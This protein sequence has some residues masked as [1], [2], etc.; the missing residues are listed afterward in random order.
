MHDQSSHTRLGSISEDVDSEDVDS[1]DVDS[2]DTEV[3]VV[4]V[5]VVEVMVEVVVAV[6]VAAA[7][8]AQSGQVDPRGWVRDGGQPGGEAISERNFRLGLGFFSAFTK[9]LKAKKNSNSRKMDQKL[10]VFFRKTQEIRKFNVNCRQNL[11]FL[12][13]NRL[14][15]GKT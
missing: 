12:L 10:K 8:H 9:K 4:V 11:Y 6:V 2:E 5:V 13:K 3:V 15:G 14:F 1:E 7:V